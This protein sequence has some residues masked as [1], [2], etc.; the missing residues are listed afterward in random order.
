M[1]ERFHYTEPPGCSGFHL[2]SYLLAGHTLCKKHNSPNVESLMSEK[3][4]GP[5]L[6]NGYLIQSND[7][8][9]GSLT[10]GIAA[11]N[12]SGPSRVISELDDIPLVPANHP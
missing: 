6:G 8:V 11:M 2:R 9:N 1:P 4:V 5:R 12:L 7:E 10:R 3:T